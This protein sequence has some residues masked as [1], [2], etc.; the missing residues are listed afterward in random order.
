MFKSTL[1]NQFLALQYQAFKELPAIIKTL[2]ILA[3]LVGSGVRILGLF[4]LG[5]YFDM[6]Y[7]QYTWGKTAF[8]MG[9]FGFWQ[10]YPMS[11]HFDYPQLSLLYEFLIVS[12]MSLFGKSDERTFVGIVKIVNWAVD[13]LIPI[14]ILWLGQ[15]FNPKN[16]QNIQ[17]SFGLAGLS[18]VLPSIWFVSGIW[19]Q[20][21]SFVVLVTLGC[22]GLLFSQKNWK[23]ESTTS[24][25][26]IS[27]IDK[28][29]YKNLA[30]WSGVLFAFGFWVKQQPILLVPI[31][32]LYFVYNK[33]WKDL[34]TAF[35]WF[36]PFLSSFGAFGSIYT[37]QQRFYEN[38]FY[39]ILRVFGLD[40]PTISNW[41][42]MTNAGIL[43]LLTSLLMLAFKL[44]Q[45]GVWREL[46]LWLFGFLLL[47]NVVSLP[48]IILNNIRYARVS[49]AP[50]IRGDSIANGAT[51]F[52]GIFPQF[53]S[54]NDPVLDF[55]NVQLSV[56][57]SGLLAYLIIFA[58]TVFVILKPPLQPRKWLK[59]QTFWQKEVSFPK[60]LIL[61]W[62]SSS[63]Y[64]LFFTNMH[65]RYLHFGILYALFVLAVNISEA[66]KKWFKI[67][68]LGVLVLHFWYL[69]N[70][71]LV[72]GANSTTPTWV[73]QFTT[74]FGSGELGADPWWWS[75]FG[76]SI[77]FATML[78][79]LAFV[80]GAKNLIKEKSV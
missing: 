3:F 24:Q 48:A 50:F 4:N 38:P 55:A 51:N 22:L 31:L 66:H 12:L 77:T 28:I 71:M 73:G 32:G 70:Q 7:T 37:E 42:I 2:F 30:F 39:Q 9:L 44:H 45:K 43:I 33:T 53:K 40:Y 6:I 61:M 46:R 47:T 15:K 1:F 80:F 49:F 58:A 69:L 14:S 34:V 36:L 19:G 23:L 56:R 67:W 20:N 76:I 79:L 52:W 16:K 63:S 25:K 78:V 54:A 72:F 75:S 27:N 17:L 13:L 65:S 5:L 74:W 62:I 26:T 11:K 21:D 59:L 8:E 60:A 18:Y 10:N 68:F 41:G 35:F 29:W 57:L 64:F